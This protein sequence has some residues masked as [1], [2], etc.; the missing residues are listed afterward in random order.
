M[1]QGTSVLDLVAIALLSGVSASLLTAFVTPTL[2]HYFWRRQRHAEACLSLMKDL[3]LLW[4][5]S[6]SFYRGDISIDHTERNELVV[7]W[8][9]LSEQT[10]S[11]FSF[12][13]WTIFI[14]FS[15][16]VTK[17]IQ[18]RR[19]DLGTF[20]IRELERNKHRAFDEL[21]R[22]IG[23][24]GDQFLKPKVRSF[25]DRFLVVWPREEPFSKRYGED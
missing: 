1:K 4:S 12:R 8:H 7:S 17:L 20:D 5:K 24:T 11:L 9:A 13:S 3:S 16:G 18:T 2:Q 23:L 10:R 15:I 21:Y 19:P 22:E 25:V 6:V 14:P